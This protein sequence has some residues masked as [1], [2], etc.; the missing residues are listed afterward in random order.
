MVELANM[1]E[2]FYIDHMLRH[3]NIYADGLT[4]SPQV[5]H[6]QFGQANMSLSEVM[7]SFAPT[8]YWR[9]IK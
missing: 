8:Q 9:K 5:W 4:S 7:T 2:E 6:Y 3:K 1:F